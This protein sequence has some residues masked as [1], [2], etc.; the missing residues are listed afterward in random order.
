M[1]CLKDAN[2]LSNLQAKSWLV[3]SDKEHKAL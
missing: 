3:G 2:K 1:K